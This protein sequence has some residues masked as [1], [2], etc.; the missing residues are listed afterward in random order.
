MRRRDLLVLVAAGVATSPFGA[1]A[2]RRELPVVGFLNSGSPEPFAAYVAALRSGLK[3]TG[4]VEGENLTIEYR[5]ARGQY[6]RLPELAADLVRRR[7]AVIVATGGDPSAKA[8]KA[9]TSTI[10]IVF[11]AGD[12]VVKSGLVTSLSR[13]GGNATGVSLLAAE[14]EAKRLELLAEMVPDARFVA[15]LVNPDLAY[16]GRQAKAVEEAARSRGQ[17]ALVLEARTEDELEVAFAVLK[18][19]RADALVVASDPFFNSRR[20]RIVSLAE[21]D[22]VPAIYEWR[23][24]VVAG[25]LISYGTSLGAAYRQFGIYTGRI[26]AGANPGDLPVLQPTQFE[27]IVNAAT[28]RSLGLALSP[29]LIARADEVIE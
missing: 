1:A 25:G 2:Q 13:P 8:A 3:E 23:E 26:L 21:R 27:L 28:A 4:F 14:L 5:W 15:V 18:R 12:D 10:P 9:A 19:E 11:G 16:A 29:A 17:R 6:E 20:D 22:R 7:V 24:F